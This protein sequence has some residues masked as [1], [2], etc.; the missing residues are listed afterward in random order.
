M[1]QKTNL[2][3]V[4]P[5]FVKKGGQT[6]KNLAQT[7]QDNASA[8]TKRKQSIAKSGKEDSPSKGPASNSPSAEVTGSKRPREGENNAPPPTKRMVVTS[9][10]KD[11]S[12][13]STVTNGLAKPAA[14]NGKP[15][16]AAAPRPKVM[17]PKPTSL[18]GALSS[19]SKR[20]GTTNAERAAA[21]A[22]SKSA[23]V[24]QREVAINTHTNFY[25]RPPAEKEK[26]AAPPPKPAFSFGEL[27]A[28]LN[29]PKETQ[30]SK[31]VE[32]K[33]PET[34]E[35]RKKRLRKEE[36]RQLRVSWKPD[37]S[38]TEIRLFTHDP[39]EELGPGDGSRKGIRDVKGEGS[40]LK[41]QKELEELEEDDLGGL[42]E[43]NLH[44]YVGLSG[45]YQHP[46][47]MNT[48]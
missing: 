9:N 19:A 1:L 2:A 5:K 12:K 43:T 8:S 10:P 41:L 44:D 4:L 32:D 30:V 33:P 7:I 37:D 46:I 31:P 21:A 34:E 42:R 45:E 15:A 11:A 38:L 25:H 24:P 28:D 29:K 14:Q 26:P 22:A 16:N 35:E 3:K 36:R 48:G 6:V 40:V 39:D 23:Y 27:M 18:F 47:G 13:P 20:P 17:A